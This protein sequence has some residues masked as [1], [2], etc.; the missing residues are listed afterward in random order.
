M[1]LPDDKLMP[2]VTEHVRLLTEA[3]CNGTA[4]V[5]QCDNLS[6]I[7]VA[8]STAAIFYAIYLRMHGELMWRWRDQIVAV[9][10]EDREESF[11]YGFFSG[12]WHDVASPVAQTFLGNT[13]SN[14][15]S[16]LSSDWLVSYLVAA[17]IFSV[18][19]L[20]TS[21]IYI[22]P[23]EQIVDNSPST[24]PAVQP[25]RKLVGQVTGLV[26]CHWS[27][28]HTVAYL[29]RRVA[30]GDE[31]AFVSGLVEVT[32][33]TGAKVLL[34]GP[35][36]Y[37]VDSPRG[38]FL[39]FG[40]LTARVEKKEARNQE[41][42]SQSLIPNALFA[43]RTPT[44]VVTDLGTEFGVEVRENGETSS[45]VFRGSV[46][47]QQT[48][49]A[50]GSVSL[51]NTIILHANEAASV[52]SR[53]NVKEMAGKEKRNKESE[54]SLSR[55]EFDATAFVLPNQMEQYAEEQ[56]L[57][58]FRRWQAYS[59]KLRKD[60]A[61]VAY[62]DFQMRG[63]NCSVLP[64]LSSASNALDGRVEGGDW[65]AGRMPGKMALYFHGPYSGDRVELPAPARFEFPD[66]FSVAVWFKA[67]RFTTIWQALITKGD[68][69]W[70][71]QRNGEA[72]QLTFAT[73]YDQNGKRSAHPNVTTGQD[74]AVDD[75][76]H[77]LVAIHE[78][79]GAVAH[80]KLCIDGRLIA[81]NDSPIPMYKNSVSV[82]IGSNLAIPG[83]E[84]FGLIDEVAIF[85]RALSVDE[86]V[87][88][89]QAGNPS[90]N[91]RE[92]IN[93]SK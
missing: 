58:S 23:P 13:F 72:N 71:I 17:V 3:V 61:L 63:D 26:D 92:N 5:E 10:D 45:H 24:A 6:E 2:R 19:S 62:Y 54:L 27:D 25:E 66:A 46:Q 31:F 51:N 55:T 15:L 37:Q 75:Q 67:S 30:A 80:K 59:Q 47:L 68:N 39:S 42:N 88:M 90:I 14:T 48:G 50:E 91:A 32:Y 43:V 84:F 79:A 7:L 44:A 89:F 33:D 1:G 82:C 36:T 65:V 29:G 11:S 8:D 34:Q 4:T 53:N 57:K 69:A 56:R 52:T 74:A 41:S 78:P 40:K 38:G 70:R 20:I 12:L 77:L 35:V 87:A 22:S 28:S 64:N 93:A 85:S 73:D 21:H 60:P 16:Y 9:K 76:W 49:V 18:G 86:V 81:E 83:R